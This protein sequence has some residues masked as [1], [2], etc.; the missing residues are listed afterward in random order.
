MSVCRVEITNQF[1]ILFDH[2]I[3]PGVRIF[4]H[5]PKDA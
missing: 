5:R 4:F 2:L 3:D 1:I